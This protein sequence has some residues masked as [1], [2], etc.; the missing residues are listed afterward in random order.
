MEML[1]ESLKARGMATR[2]LRRNLLMKY[3][4]KKDLEKAEDIKKVIHF[5]D[6][7]GEKYVNSICAFLVFG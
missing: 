5:A 1:Y 2:L 7:N 3:C 6:W 4:R